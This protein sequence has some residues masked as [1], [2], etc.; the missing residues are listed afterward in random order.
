MPVFRPTLVAQPQTN[1]VDQI[2]PILMS[3]QQ[4]LQAL[5]QNKKTPTP[6]ATS[7]AAQIPQT[8]EPIGEE[9][10]KGA[11]PNTDNLLAARWPKYTQTWVKVSKPKLVSLA[12]QPL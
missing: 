12:K 6:A 9:S 5:V 3:I 1:V 7:I 2:S 11:T 10:T 8:V 4:A